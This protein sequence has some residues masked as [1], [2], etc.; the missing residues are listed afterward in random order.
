MVGAVGV[1]EHAIAVVRL[2]AVGPHSKPEDADA[3]S[4]N[5]QRS[6]CGV[7]RPGSPEKSRWL[8]H[9][10]G[11][12]LGARFLVAAS[13]LI[14]RPP[15]APIQ[16]TCYLLPR[17]RPA[18]ER[19]GGLTRRVHAEPSGCPNRPASRPLLLA[20]LP[21]AFPA[22]RRR[23]EAARSPRVSYGYGLPAG[24]ANGTGERSPSAPTRTPGGSKSGAA[25]ALV[26][27]EIMVRTSDIGTLRRARRVFGAARC[28]GSF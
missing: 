14:P 9:L 10:V 21:G 8:F 5:Y 27:T 20:S 6:R 28:G 1:S 24:A 3:A 17:P 13:R 23:S 26:G 15:Q 7:D 2:Q 16:R 12:T 11:A 4:T 19:A 22:V 18:D 25:R